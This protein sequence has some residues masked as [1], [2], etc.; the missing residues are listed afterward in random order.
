MTQNKSKSRSMYVGFDPTADSLH[1]GN[2]VTLI[3]LLHFQQHGYQPI[4]VVGGA[5]GLIGDPSGRLKERDSLLKDDLEQNV[6][7]I[8]NVLSKIFQNALYLTQQQYAMPDLNVQQ[9]LNSGQGLSFTEF[10]YQVFQAY[11]Y[12]CL[13]QNH[14][15]WLQVSPPKSMGNISA[16]CE[17]VH[18]YTGNRVHGLTVPLVT[19]SSGEKLGKSVGNAVWLSADKTSPYHLY[20]YFLKTSDEDVSKYLYYFTFTSLDYISDILTQ[21]QVKCDDSYKEED[22]TLIIKEWSRYMRNGHMTVTCYKI[23][24]LLSE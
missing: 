20:Q 18:K 10:S 22:C 17:F 9:R 2:L 11:D 21:H 13:H 23:K 14:N 15:C 12:L 19:T 1:I 6:I 24:S 4:A 7:G 8:S 16:G 5:T 3:T